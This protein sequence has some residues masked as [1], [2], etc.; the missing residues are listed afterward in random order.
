FV[1][2]SGHPRG[3]PPSGSR[4]VRTP[5]PGGSRPVPTV[6]KP[7]RRSGEYPGQ[8]VGRNPGTQEFMEVPT[9]EGGCEYARTGRLPATGVSR[10][11]GA[12]RRAP[13]ETRMTRSVL[14]AVL[15]SAVLAGCSSDSGSNGVP[16]PRGIDRNPLLT[17]VTSCG[18]LERAIED[19]LVLEMKSSIEQLRKYD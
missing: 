8:G 3:E 15:L 14:A 7:P 6:N 19:A 10:A 12:V 18:Q 17:Q 11:E 16:S 9:L 13:S 5:R 1:T 4:K 2:T